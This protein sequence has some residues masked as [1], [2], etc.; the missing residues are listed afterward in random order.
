[1]VSAG[2]GRARP[3]GGQLD[4][5]REPV[6]PAAEL[7]DRCIGRVECVAAGRGGALDEE[8]RGFGTTARVERRHDVEVLTGEIE[9]LPAR[10]E[11][12]D[13]GTRCE[14][15]VRDGGGRIEQVLAVVEDDECVA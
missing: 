2:T 6:E 3:C 1:M 7:R 12:H 5:E 11:Q 10:G 8:L 9:R 15:A 13:F 4:R 14:H